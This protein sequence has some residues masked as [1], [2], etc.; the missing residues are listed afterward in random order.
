[1]DAT[2]ASAGKMTAEA[3]KQREA[4]VR[5]ATQMGMTKGEAEKLATAYGLGTTALQKYQTTAAATREAKLKADITDLQSK[6]DTAQKELKDPN[7]TKERKAKL[8]AD[9]AALQSAIAK[10]KSSIDSVK[11]KT[12]TVNVQY[13]ESGR[14]IINGIPSTGAHDK[15]HG[16]I[17]GAAGGGPRSAMTLVGEQGPE[18]VSLPFG[19][20]VHTAGATRNML[21]QGGSGGNITVNLYVQ[22][23]IRSDR[24]LISLVRNEMVNGGFRGALNNV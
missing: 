10:A 16:G 2:G 19:S 5:Q 3:E 7:L 23:S 6:L 9:I 17:V 12:V 24:D 21:S 4:F 20:T 1:M 15:A 18:L 22:G 14:S 8:N 13:T 11:G